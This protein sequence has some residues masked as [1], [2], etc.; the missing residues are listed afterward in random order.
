[1]M[2]CLVFLSIQMHIMEET[3]ITSCRRLP[4]KTGQ[5][6]QQ[7][8]NNVKLYSQAPEDLSGLYLVFW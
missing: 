3:N 2:S 6:G 8:V 4:T 5:E 1:M 7:R